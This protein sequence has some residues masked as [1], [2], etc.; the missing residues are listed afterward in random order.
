MGAV[1]GV[2][3]SLGKEMDCDVIIP[4]LAVRSRPGFSGRLW[5][6]A[7]SGNNWL[8]LFG[9]GWLGGL[10]GRLWLFAASGNNWLDFFGK[11]WLGGLP[12]RLWLFAASGKAWLEPA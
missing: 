3:R 2:A 12:G 11:G 9:K 10:P 7:A 5:L 1:V 4:W 6:L 8:G